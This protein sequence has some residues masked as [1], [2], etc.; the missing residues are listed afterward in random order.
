MEIFIIMSF[1]Q[2]QLKHIAHL[3]RL[4]LTKEELVR[5]EK[6]GASI[7]DF[8]TKLT[9]VDTEK[10]LPLAHAAEAENVMREDTSYR[11][12]LPALDLIAKAPEVKERWLKVPPILER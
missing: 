2:D 4:T 5:F 1:T 6:E 11:E 12:I 9:E 8:F 3:A 10:V 7:L